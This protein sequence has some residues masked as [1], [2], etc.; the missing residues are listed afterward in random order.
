MQLRTAWALMAAC[1]FLAPV[2]RSPLRSA[3]PVQWTKTFAG[4]GDADGQCV[5]QTSDGGYIAV[6]TTSSADSTPRD[7]VLLVKLDAYGNTQWVKTFKGVG[8]MI[9]AAVIQTSDGGFVL[10][11]SAAADK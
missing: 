8:G 6:G 7:A 2:P 5:Q 10:A 4:W 9:G 11:G 1:L 3:P